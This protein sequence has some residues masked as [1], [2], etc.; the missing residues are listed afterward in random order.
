MKLY[1]EYI[2]EIQGATL[3]LEED[4]AFCT[5]TLLP[6]EYIYLIDIYVAPAYR[7]ENITK[8]LLN[9]VIEIGKENKKTRVLG[10]VCTNNIKY[11]ISKKFVEHMNFKLLNIKGSMLYYFLEI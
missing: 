11:K 6:N 8:K 4:K 7:K 2:K 9:K 3:I 10:S 5:Y 1:E